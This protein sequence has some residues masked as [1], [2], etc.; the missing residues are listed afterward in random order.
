[1]DGTDAVM[2]SAETAIGKYP[3]L[4]VQ[5]MADICVGAERQ[6]VTMVSS[7][8]L[9]TEFETHEEAVAMAAMYAANHYDVRAIVAMTESGRTAKWMSRIS[10]GLPIFAMSR[11]IGTLRRVTLYRGVYPI[12]F[13]IKDGQRGD[14]AQSDVLKELLRLGVVSKG[15]AVIVT[16][17]ELTGIIGGT[18]S[19]K[20]LI[21]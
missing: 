14:E 4:V 16:H 10:S 20:I 19:M 9:D 11:Q 21:V 18:N 8:R 2:L 1:M 12:F 13:D 6:R 15:D 17:G 3:V 5:R 7:H